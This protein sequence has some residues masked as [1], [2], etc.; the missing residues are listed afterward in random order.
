MIS[1]HIKIS[2]IFFLIFIWFA[3]F[4]SLNLNPLEFFQ[5]SLI[6]KIRLTIP[7]LFSLILITFSLNQ[8]ETSKLFKIPYLFFYLIFI[9][10]IY[11]NLIN[12]LNNNFNVFW[13][14]YMLLS[15]FILQT[16]TNKNEKVLLLKFTIL[17]IVFIF[18][19]FLSSGLIELYLTNKVH[20]Y[21]I[22]LAYSGGI[23]HPP[24]SSGLAR[25]S[26]I[27]YAFLTVS[28]IC[29]NKIKNY[30]FLFL[31]SFFAVFTLL[32]QS[33]T[34]SFIFL[35]IN[36][37]FILFYF[38]R[39]FYDKRLIFFTIIFPF[40]FNFSYSLFVISYYQ[41]GS[42]LKVLSEIDI[43]AVSKNSIIRKH[44]VITDSDKYS[45]GRFG[46]WLSALEIIKKNPLKGYGAQADRVYIKQSIHNAF[47][48]STLSG[49][50]IAGFCII[51]IYFYSMWLLLKIYFIN[52]IKFKNNIEINFCALLIVILN[53]RSILETSF[54]VFSID[55]LIFILAVSIL[56]DHLIKNKNEKSI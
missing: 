28:Y 48:Y 44:A 7:L 22:G 41:T 27:I 25:L 13:P 35:F 56:N 39:F 26:L 2:K 15:F 4:L 5:L 50:L 47:I 10:Y 12:S 17:M 49:G 43:F 55:F 14:I 46:N 9:L 21:G 18:I 31:I 8:I 51:L 30:K 53:L 37:L 1:A 42:R 29:K 16:F 36:I 20:L 6:N 11:F 19:F 52:R 34:T 32:F 54:A 38:N 23:E 33:R 3:F 24:R 40:L 45:S